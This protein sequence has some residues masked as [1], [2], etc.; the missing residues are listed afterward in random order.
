MSGTS[1]LEK[2]PTRARKMIWQHLLAADFVRQPVGQYLI[3]HYKFETKVLL[4]NKAIYAEASGTLSKNVFA[5]VHWQNHDGVTTMLNHEVPLFKLTG[6]KAFNNHSVDITIKPNSARLRAA[7]PAEGV[8]PCLMLAQDIPKLARVLQILDMAN[9]AEFSFEFKFRDV[10]GTSTHDEITARTS[11]LLL[12][13]EKVRGVKAVQKVLIT[14]PVDAAIAIRVRKA[15]TQK[16]SWLRADAWDMYSLALS[17]KRYGDLAFSIG[18]ADMT[19]AKYDDAYNFHGAAMTTN[20]E[21]LSIS[22]EEW[23]YA[24]AR[25]DVTIFTDLA[26]MM[27]AD[28]TLNDKDL[29]ERQYSMVPKYTKFI[30]VGERMNS[31]SPGKIIV[32]PEVIA[33]FYHLLGIAELGLDHPVKAAK[34]FVKAHGMTKAPK[35]KEGC[36]LA[37]DWKTRSADHRQTRLDALLAAM[38][39]KPFDLPDVPAYITHEVE[40]E[41][42]VIE[43]LGFKG[44]LPYA[45]KINGAFSVVMTNKPH[46]NQLRPQRDLECLSS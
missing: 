6:D 14:G 16:V 23:H 5:K 38:P 21:T 28:M 10:T 29:G 17:I 46:P 35:S 4:V 42:W 32:P 12:P 11:S 2:L 34:A 3:E 9:S 1:R 40:P 36:Q 27:L 13:F 43:Q 19:L 44:T 45:D 39:K 24:M 31:S 22:D 25:L 26:L 30:E 33:R 8:P 15:M 41:K 37:K 18:D 7:A 20:S